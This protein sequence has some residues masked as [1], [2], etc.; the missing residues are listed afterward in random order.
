MIIHNTDTTLQTV[1]RLRPKRHHQFSLENPEGHGRL[2]GLFEI[3]GMSTLRGRDGDG[4]RMGVLGSG[5]ESVF[6]MCF[7]AL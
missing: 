7:R 1:P 2:A 5:E 3:P 6:K 4:M